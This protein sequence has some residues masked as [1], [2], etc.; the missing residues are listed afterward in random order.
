MALMFYSSRCGYD[1][2]ISALQS[3]VGDASPSQPETES[4]NAST[5]N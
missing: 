1:E 5:K 3:D 2:S 4:T